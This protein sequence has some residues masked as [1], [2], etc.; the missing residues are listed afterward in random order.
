M[1]YT[2][3]TYYIYI[4]YRYRW[5]QRCKEGGRRRRCMGGRDRERWRQA[6]GGEGPSCYS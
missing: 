4:I 5:G 6:K 3:N 1:I 2:Y